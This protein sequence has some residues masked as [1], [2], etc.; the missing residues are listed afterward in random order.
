VTGNPQLLGRGPAAAAYPVPSLDFTVEQ[1]GTLE[2]AAVP[3]IRFALRVDGPA[4]VP[5][6][7]I[8][9]ATQIRIAAARRSYA[10]AERD[11]LLE[12]LGRPEQWAGSSRTLFWAQVASQ[13]TGFTGTT[14]VDLP[15]PCTYDF[16]VASAKYLHGVEEGEV[17]LEFIFSGSVFYRDPEGALKTGRIA[18]DR[19][20]S[21]RLPVRVWKETMD[22]FFPGTAW[23][24]LHR[25]VFE[26]LHAYR[27]D[28]A[29]PSWEATIEALLDGAG[30]G[31]ER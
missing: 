11:R 16:E 27:S 6:R 29:I 31:G 14:R 3:T 24:R 9:L 7:S 20:S 22:H 15:V 23:L 4:D 19:E 30:P 1:A 12:V 13:V 2:F 8:S 18:W 28:R 10:P 25:D 21:F 17:P 26:R 5:I